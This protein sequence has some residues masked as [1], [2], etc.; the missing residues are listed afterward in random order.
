M[1]GSSWRG[2]AGGAFTISFSADGRYLG[3]LQHAHCVTLWDLERGSVISQGVSENVRTAAALAPDGHTFALGR[4]D[5]AVT[6]KVDRQPDFFDRTRRP[7]R[8]GTITDIQPRLGH[9]GDGQL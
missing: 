6:L 8:S 3:V 2:N 5:G 4:D 7:V 9:L 1:S